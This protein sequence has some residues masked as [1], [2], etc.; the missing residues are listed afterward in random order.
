MSNA[1]AFSASMSVRVKRNKTM[2]LGLNVIKLSTMVI[3]LSMVLL[4]FCIMKQ[5]YHGNYHKMAANY[6]G[7][8]FM[9]IVN[10]GKLKY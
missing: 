1:L 4:S 9:T 5:Y 3:F 6:H 7:K 8:R 10:G 2:A